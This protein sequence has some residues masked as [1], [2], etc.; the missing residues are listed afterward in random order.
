MMM[1]S[2]SKKLDAPALTTG[3]RRNRIFF[4]SHP[5]RDGIDF[6]TRGELIAARK[7]VEELE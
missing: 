4:Y 3:Y 7:T 6:P 1:N 5:Q 2:S